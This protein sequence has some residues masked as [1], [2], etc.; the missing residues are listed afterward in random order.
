MY[1]G[2]MLTIAVDSIY[3]CEILLLLILIF[4][5]V[6]M[7]ETYTL[8]RKSTGQRQGTYLLSNTLS[9]FVLFLLF[10]L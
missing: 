9:F 4:V 1:V 3:S 8:L 7:S 6:V 10:E 5:I 2:T